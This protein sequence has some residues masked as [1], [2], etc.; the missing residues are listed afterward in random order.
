MMD[1]VVNGKD[2][3]VKHVGE[4]N[5]NINQY[6]YHSVEGDKSSVSLMC[7]F[8]LSDNIS[9]NQVAEMISQCY[10]VYK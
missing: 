8:I 3:I 5:I 2:P 10:G 4:N 6:L 1:S 9:L 7:E